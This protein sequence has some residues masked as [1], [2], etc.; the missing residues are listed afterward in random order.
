MN[1]VSRAVPSQ[2][3]S[4]ILWHIRIGM[5]LQRYGLG[6]GLECHIRKTDWDTNLNVTL[7]MRIET[8]LGM[9]LQILTKA[10]EQYTTHSRNRA[11][12]DT[13]KTQKNHAG[14]CLGRHHKLQDDE[15]I[16][17]VKH[18]KRNH[19]ESPIHQKAEVYKKSCLWAKYLATLGTRL[20]TQ[21]WSHFA[22]RCLFCHCDPCHP[23]SLG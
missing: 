7:E 6:Y 12:H 15:V 2:E 13:F 1:C 11:V 21:H 20:Q 5:I 17:R 22:L 16:T 9:S 14:N 18:H 10:K 23:L 4:R 3:V 8:R 19:K